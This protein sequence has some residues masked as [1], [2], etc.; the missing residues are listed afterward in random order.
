MKTFTDTHGRQWTV[1]LNIAAVKRVR[2]LAG[3]DLLA[4]SSDDASENVITRLAGDPVLL[5]DVV[6]AVCKP[7]ADAADLGDEDFG[8]A[9][10]G[11]AIDAATRALL[12]ELADFFPNRRDRQ[13]ARRVLTKMDALVD[14]AQDLLDAETSE[15]R[16]DAEIDAAVETLGET[17]RSSR[18][19]SAS[20]R[21]G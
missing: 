12:E 18:A 21:P 15:E 11:D 6:Y 17:L 13:R 7:E 1:A 10:A 8:R 5:C 14:R 19:P 2:D 16:L 4:A 3:V 9:M 20:T